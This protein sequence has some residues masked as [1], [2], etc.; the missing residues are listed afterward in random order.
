MATDAP[1]GLPHDPVAGDD[2]RHA[3]EQITDQLAAAAGP[4][5]STVGSETDVVEGRA[6]WSA[7]QRIPVNTYETTEAMVIVAPM[8]GVMA[9]D[10]DV[11][12]RGRQVTLR[13]RLRSAAPKP[14]L[15]HEWDYGDYER[16][17]RSRGTTR[18]GSRRR[19]GTVSWR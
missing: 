14:Y 12:V 11:S 5:D 4:T 16:S 15:I 13:A 2:T 3:V 18:V 1:L 10:V 19:W 9:D 7:S 6:H 8:P 17:P